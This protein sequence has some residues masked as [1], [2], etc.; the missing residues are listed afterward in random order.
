MLDI[1]QITGLDLEISSYC[2]ASCPMCPRNFY[3]MKHN[4]GY[5]VTN[6]TLSQFQVAFT[7]EFMSQIDYVKFNGNFGDFNMNPEGLE[8]L[9]YIRRHSADARMDVHTN[10]HSRDP[11]YWRD[12]A[13]TR[14]RVYFDIDGLEDTHHLHRQGTD[15]HRIMDH[16]RQH[17]AAGG[18]AIW[19]ML[20]F[21]HNRHQEEQCRQMSRDL[22]FSDFV[23]LNDGRDHAHVFSAQGEYS[24]T[25]GDPRHPAPQQAETLMQWK[26][27]HQAAQDDYKQPPKASVHCLA[28]QNRR[29]YMA[30]NGDIYPCCWLGFSPRTYD[31][32]LYTGNDQIRA[33]LKHAKNNAFEHGLEQSIA[34]FSEVMQS[35]QKQSYNEGRLYRCDLHCGRN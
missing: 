28:R 30:S 12:L 33:L 9:R 11:Q 15:W 18:H 10:G 31:Q 27:E 23:V 35:W 5:P 29:I 26:K 17:I 7:P 19:K 24:H 3:G 14:P 16:A 8:I 4:A 21:D 2:V 13:E 34:W 25:I 6:V 20:V 1:S 32:Q 22:G